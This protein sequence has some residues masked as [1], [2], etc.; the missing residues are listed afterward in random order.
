MITTGDLE[1]LLKNF[2]E[3][4]KIGVPQI[5]HLLEKLIE[6]SKTDDA[7]RYKSVP[8]LKFPPLKMIKSLPK[9]INGI[10]QEYKF[11]IFEVH[12]SRYCRIVYNEG[13]N[14]RLFLDMME[15]GYC[16]EWNLYSSYKSY[17]LTVKGYEELK[18]DCIRGYN[19]LVQNLLY[20][21]ENLSKRWDKD[22]IRGDKE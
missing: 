3:L 20:S 12:G 8:D 10:Y 19:T 21:N 6:K 14:G 18:K 16:G 1:K 5:E 22:M 17:D 15:R 7:K 13:G 9:E 2:S 11:D 4:N